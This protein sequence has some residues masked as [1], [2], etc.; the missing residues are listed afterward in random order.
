VVSCENRKE[1]FSR[2]VSN[3]HGLCFIRRLIFIHYLFIPSERE[4]QLLGVC[5]G[6]I[7]I[8][9]ATRT[10]LIYRSI[11]CEWSAQFQIKFIDLINKSFA[12]RRD[13]EFGG[14]QEVLIANE[15]V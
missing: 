2:L 14:I 10:D 9:R 3:C 11:T 5:G 13:T 15:F 4:T 1:G 7:K 12:H 6:Q 8:N